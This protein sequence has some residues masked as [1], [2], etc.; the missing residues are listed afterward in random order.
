[1]ITLADAGVRQS[2][3]DRIATLSPA[4]RR[5]WGRM[6]AHQAICHLNDSFGMALGGKQASMASGVFQRTLMKWF[7][8]NVPLEWPKGLATRPE[9]E[10]G[11]G[12]TPP[13][14]FERDRAQLVQLIERFCDVR[15]SFETQPH[16]TFGL[17]RKEEWMRWGY[18]HTDHHLRQFSA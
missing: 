12:G 6:T 18:L 8:L 17:M 3:L 14:E 1:M 5:Q 2:I 16:P 13:Q 4:S 7:A 11:A 9:M 10:Q 15:T